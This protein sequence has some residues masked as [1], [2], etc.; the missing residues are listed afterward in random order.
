VGF[1]VGMFVGMLMGMAL[2]RVGVEMHVE[3]HALDVPAALPGKVEMEFVA[4][5]EL[6][7][8]L[9]EMSLVHPKVTKSS[10]GHVAADA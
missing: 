5:P 2:V 6:R 3:L 1:V 10:H 7:E 9:R 4:E 8:F